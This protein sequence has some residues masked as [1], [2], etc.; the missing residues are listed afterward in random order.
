M[1]LGGIDQPVIGQRRIEMDLRMRDGEINLIGGLIKETNDKSVT[2]IP[3]LGSIPIVG[4]LFK[5][6]SITKSQAELLIVMV[7]HIIR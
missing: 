7:P 5:S 1:N 4:N 6:T 2:G 3:G